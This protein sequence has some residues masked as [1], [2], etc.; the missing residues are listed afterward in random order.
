VTSCRIERVDRNTLWQR[1]VFACDMN[2]C[3]N[4][5][6]LRVEMR[7]WNDLPSIQFLY[8]MRKVATTS[9]EAV[10]VAFPFAGD[11]AALTYDGQGGEVVPGTGQV[12]G[13][14]ADW[15]T[16]QQYVRV[17]DGGGQI[18]L[19]SPRV[20]LVQL[21]GLN[22]G[23]WRYAPEI[24]RPHVFS[25]VM[26]NYWWTNFRAAQ[27]G[28]WSWS[29]RLTSTA[30]GS[31]AAAA[32]FG[33]ECHAPLAARIERLPP[34]LGGKSFLRVQPHNVVVVEA[35][36]DDGGSGVILQLRELEGADT[37]AHMEIPEGS[38]VTRVEEVDVTGRGLRPLTDG[39]PLAGFGVRFVRVDLGR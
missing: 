38:P 16:I 9:P 10:Y 27:G 21:G 17:A 5:G 1:V 8:R 23:A 37:L 19:S 22:L 36:P 28:E 33:A 34:L 39:I 15:Q 26:N 25:W 20:P 4:P 14:S 32:R 35:R 24:P 13:S 29:Y 12:E 11:G 31:R 18:I 3:I 7:L 6:G 30:E 2:G